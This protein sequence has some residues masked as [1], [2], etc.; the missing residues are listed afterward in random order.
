MKNIVNSDEYFRELGKIEGKR[1]VPGVTSS[2]DEEVV[3]VEDIIEGDFIEFFRKLI[4]YVDPPLIKSGG[5]V[6]DGCILTTPNGQ[7]FQ[8][9]SCR[10]DLEGWRK[11]ISEGANGLKIA[12]GHIKDNILILSNGDLVRLEDCLVKFY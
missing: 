6:L 4:R 5:A 9:I 11:Q 3:Y 12:T 8:A 10:G 1:G 2:V 7:N